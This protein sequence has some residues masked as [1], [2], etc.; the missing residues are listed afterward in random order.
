M[1]SRFSN[2]YPS[3]FITLAGTRLCC[4]FTSMH[5]LVFAPHF[6]KSQKEFCLENAFMCI[7][8]FLFSKV[9]LPKYRLDLWYWMWYGAWLYASL[10]CFACVLVCDDSCVCGEIE[11]EESR[12]RIVD[13]NNI[14]P[15]TYAKPRQ[16][17][18]LNSKLVLLLFNILFSSTLQI[19]L[20]WH[21]CFIILLVVTWP[22]KLWLGVQR[23]T[24]P[25]LVLLIPLD[26]WYDD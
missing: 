19:A 16:A 24:H 14:S 25:L 15:G 20:F 5:D 1:S 10:V 17:T 4:Y 23:D 3:I 13:F 12:R 26:W 2:I 22:P 18:F 7:L 6:L 11:E 8:V 9:V 21:E